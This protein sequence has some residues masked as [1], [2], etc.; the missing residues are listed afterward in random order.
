MKDPQLQFQSQAVTDQHLGS[1]TAQTFAMRCPD[2]M[3]TTPVPA[4]HL[5]RAGILHTVKQ[6]K[7]NQTMM[8]KIPW[9]CYTQKWDPSVPVFL[10]PAQWDPKKIPDREPQRKSFENLRTSLVY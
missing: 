9:Q 2:L 6:N 1:P 10:D 3:E 4:R 8:D 7:P 5:E